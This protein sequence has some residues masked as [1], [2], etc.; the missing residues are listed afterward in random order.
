[1]GTH[2]LITCFSESGALFT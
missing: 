1:M 2:L